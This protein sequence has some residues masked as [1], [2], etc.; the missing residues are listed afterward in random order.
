MRKD[1]IDIQPS[2]EFIVPESRKQFMF[3]DRGRVVLIAEYEYTA[4]QK[5]KPVSAR[6]AA[7]TYVTVAGLVWFGANKTCWDPEGNGNGNGVEKTYS[8]SGTYKASDGSSIYHSGTTSSNECPGSVESG[9][10]TFYYESGCTTKE[11]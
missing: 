10:K 9:G 7:M 5:E 6:Q 3:N 2:I 11:N 1:R 4:K 8:F